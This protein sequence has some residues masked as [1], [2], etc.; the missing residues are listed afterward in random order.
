MM[1]E[2][3]KLPRPLLCLLKLNQM[4]LHEINELSSP[5]AIYSLKTPH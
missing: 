4:F 5:T 1:D 3:A 2:K